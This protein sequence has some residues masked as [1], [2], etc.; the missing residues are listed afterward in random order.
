MLLQPLVVVA[1]TPKQGAQTT[2]YCAVSEEME[3]VTGQYL[4]DCK[5]TKTVHPQLTDD[6]LVERL[7]EVSAKLTELTESMIHEAYYD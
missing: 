2:I 3:G 7:W 5:I 1:K 4:S 6:E